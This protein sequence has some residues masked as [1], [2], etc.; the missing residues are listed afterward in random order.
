[1]RE[2]RLF[3]LAAGLSSSAVT[4]SAQSSSDYAA[5]AALAYTPVGALPPMPLPVGSLSS[6][7][8][9]VVRYGHVSAGDDVALNDFGI[10]GQFP[11]SRGTVGLTVGTITCGGCGVKPLMLGVDWGV[12][13]FA[14][15]I[16]IGIRPSVGFSHFFVD[17][18]E[19]S[20]GGDALSA[21]LSLPISIPLP[22]ESGGFVIPFLEP[23]L[24]FGRVSGGGDSE[25]GT[26]P[27]IGGGLMLSGLGGNI[28][29]HFGF[30]KV[31]IDGG[32]AQFGV[33]LMIGGQRR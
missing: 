12:P 17:D 31:I 5:Y 16:R 33:G 14:T 30:E 6:S 27:M 20:D 2:I 25:S 26:R 11:V 21:A 7:S 28:G 18:N 15:T 32:R 22:L 24:G 9:F 3:V 1:M 8:A 10:G 13:L 4:A 19:G 29:L 23:G